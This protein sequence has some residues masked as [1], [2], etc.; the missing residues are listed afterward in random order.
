LSPVE[1]QDS[2]FVSDQIQNLPH[3]TARPRKTKT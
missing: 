2:T 3:K 1:D